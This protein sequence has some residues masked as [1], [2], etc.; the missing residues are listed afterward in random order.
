MRMIQDTSSQ[1]DIF[2]LIGID[3]MLL[4]LSFILFPFLWRDWKLIARLE[5]SN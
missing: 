1:N 3:L 4:A 2:I 5:P